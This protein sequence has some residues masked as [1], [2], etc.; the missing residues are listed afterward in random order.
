VR[1]DD[2]DSQ[3]LSPPSDD[4]SG[5]RYHVVRCIGVG[6]KSDTFLCQ[7]LFQNSQEVVRRLFHEEFT[8]NNPDLND[9]VFPQLA[10]LEHPNLARIIDFGVEEGRSFLV[11]E[12]A[13]GLPLLQALSGVPRPQVL[14]IFGQLLVVLDFLYAQN[15]FHLSLK[16]ENI[17]V[18][19]ATNPWTLKVLDYGI[20]PLIYPTTK[21]ESNTVG[22][23]P[24][25][26]PEYAMGRICDTRSD[27]YSVGVL[28]YSALAQRLP[29]EGKDTVSLFQ[30]QLKKDPAPLQGLVPGIPPKLSAFVQKLMAR[31]PQSRFPSP[32]V[33]LKAL[34]EASDDPQLASRIHLPVLFSDPEEVFRYQEYLKLFRRVALQGGRWAII[35]DAGSGKTFLARWL[36][37]LF[38]LNHKPVHL[39]NGKTIA[40]LEGEH[41]LNPSEPTYVLID[42]ADQGP[43]EAWL[44]ARPYANVVTFIQDKA[45]AQ[46]KSG[47]QLY[48]LKALDTKLL[49]GVLDQS[50]GLSGDRMTQEWFLHTHGELRSLIQ[51]GRALV[52]QGLIQASGMQWRCDT[53]KYLKAANSSNK[54]MLGAPLAS[55]PE[56]P[57]RVMSLLAFLQ[58]PIGI[59]ALMQW[60]GLSAEVL[61]EHLVFLSHEELVERSLNQGQEYFRSKMTVPWSMDSSIGAEQIQNWIEGLYQLEWYNGAVTAFDR[62][63]T[64]EPLKDPSQILLKAKLSGAAGL[65]DV[66]FASVTSNFVQSLPATQKSEAF[67]IFGKSLLETGKGKQAE[68]AFRNAYTQ[69]KSDQDHEGQART[70]MHLGVLANQMGDQSK[71]VKFFEQSL[72][73]AEQ[74]PQPELV[75]GKIEFH[76]ADLYANATDFENAESRFHLSMEKLSQCQQEVTLAQVFGAYAQMSFR[77]GDMFRSEYMVR[78]GLRRAVFK[79]HYPTQGALLSV[80]AQIEQQKGNIRIAAERLAEAVFVLSKSNDPLA[81]LR[82]LIERA[83]FYETNRELI[84]ASQDANDALQEAKRL[85][86]T[87][88]EAQAHL[89][90]GKVIRRDQHRMKDAVHHLDLAY[91]KFEA[92]K[93]VRKIWECFFEK[94]EIE[95][96]Q[97]NA[98]QA[99]AHYEQAV[100][101]LDQALTQLV[102]GTAESF[103]LTQKREQ[104]EMILGSL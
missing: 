42:N 6:A 97:G 50:L 19:K 63:F 1:E 49:G 13:R 25:T 76:I 81:H 69:Y 38:W 20:A 55:L 96:Y 39:F 30:S 74:A 100:A 44:R 61:R 32:R 64:Q 57:R 102:P 14:P 48:P 51:H 60:T 29:F 35:G 78:E 77:L 23:P 31:D 59:D 8:N 46:K 24:Y 91:R 43:V 7:D 40:L 33:A 84:L 53:E 66:V 4:P 92:T 2:L 11:S 98:P 71:A 75:Q 72:I 80:W 82:A 58:V 88:L 9:H 104:L 101:F 3:S 86:A 17:L 21:M 65:H 47:W 93:N 99:R 34:L 36:Q 15:L 27:L 5:T 67:E 16:P 68:A 62:Y 87:E 85:Q 41:T 26:A 45:W 22:T 70:L 12:K 28:L 90:L 83:N 54:E 37:R 10:A 73:E 95:R 56:E 103:A 18:D 79:S 52:R 94:G 89:I